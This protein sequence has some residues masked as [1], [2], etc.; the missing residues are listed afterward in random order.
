MSTLMP[1]P[2]CPD[3]SSFVVCFEIGKCESPYF[4]PQNCLGYNGFLEFPHEFDY[5]LIYF[6]KISAEI[7]TEIAFI[8]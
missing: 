6:C 4:V 7:L 5:M 3:Y 1:V 8:L 2:C